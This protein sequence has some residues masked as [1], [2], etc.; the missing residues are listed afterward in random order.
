MKR[1]LLILSLALTCFYLPALAQKARVGI[2]AGVTMSNLTGETGGVNTSYDSRGGFT[3]GIIVDAPIGKTRFTFQPGVHYVQKGAVT[4]E[5]KEQK[6]YVALRYAEFAFHFLYNTKGA[7]GINIFAGIG[8]TVSLNLPSKTVTK[9]LDDD[10]KVE[11]NVIF[12]DEGAAQFNGIDYGA[13]A[14]AGLN[15]RNGALLSFNYNHG[16]RNLMPGKDS[17]DA[18]RNSCFIIRLGLLI[19]NK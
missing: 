13:S 5:T 15:F 18:I 17:E 19:R 2:V 10:T 1:T 4:D 16:I 8:P 3:T 14:I 11:Q 7:K 6:N 12:G 9:F